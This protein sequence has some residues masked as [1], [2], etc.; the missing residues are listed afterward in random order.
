MA[1]WAKQRNDDLGDR[2]IGAAGNH[3]FYAKWAHE[4]GGGRGVEAALFIALVTSSCPKSLYSILQQEK[5]KEMPVSKPVTFLAAIFLAWSVPIGHA[6]SPRRVEI[7][8]KRF[9]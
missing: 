9:T 6:Q 2:A 4:G 5:R 3:G 7:I 1:D 8:A